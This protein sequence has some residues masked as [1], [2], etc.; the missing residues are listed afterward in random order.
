[1]LVFTASTAINLKCYLGTRRQNMETKQST[2]GKW[3]HGKTMPVRNV[4]ALAAD[5]AELT[6]EAIKRYIRPARADDVAVAA[7]GDDSSQSIPVIDLGMLLD[8][9][10]YQLEAARLK[11]ACEEWGFFQ[12]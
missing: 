6:E 4:Q 5:A 1:M 3:S 8:S 2:E 10:N 9:Q 11:S 7:H 12:V